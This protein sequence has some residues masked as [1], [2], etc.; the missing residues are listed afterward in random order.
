MIQTRRGADPVPDSWENTTETM[1]QKA[2]N[3][4]T[5]AAHEVSINTAQTHNLRCL[6]HSHRCG[7]D[8]VPKTASTLTRTVLLTSEMRR[9]SPENHWLI[10]LS[11]VSFFESDSSRCLTTGFLGCRRGEQQ[12]RQPCGSP[13]SCLISVLHSGSGICRNPCTRTQNQLFRRP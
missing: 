7:L 4:R 9:T 1:Q 2:W 12:G 5:S 3:Y 6:L 11:F 13:K 8:R 10:P